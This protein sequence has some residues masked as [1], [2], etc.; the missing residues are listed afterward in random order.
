[1]SQS[2]AEAITE[3]EHRKHFVAL[4]GLRGL[5]AISVV[6]FHFMEMAILDYTKN[7]IGHGFLAVDFFF[8]LSGFVMGYAYDDRIRTLGFIRF[9]RHRLIRLHP[10]VVF[11]AVLG[12][13][14]FLFDPFM[15][16]PAS[17]GVGRI[18]ML[19]LTTLLVVPYPT[20]VE[21]THNLF[22]LNAPEWSLFWE[23]IASIVYALVLWRVARPALGVL[24]CIAALWLGICGYR[25]GWIYNGWDANGFW[26][27]AA[28]VS[29][30]FLAGLFIY[31][32]HL[33]WKNNLHFY[34]IGALLVLTFVMPF[35]SHE[36]LAEEL[37]VFVFYP[38][39]IMMGAG[40]HVSGVTEKLCS[41]LGR[42]SYPLY[43]THYV[44]LWIFMNFYQHHTIGY[45]MT[46]FIIGLSV[47][48]LTI[49]AYGVMRFVDEPLRRRLRHME[50]S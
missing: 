11:G 4:D 33:I 46:A 31:R 25:D 17:Y 30:S 40:I 7:F 13:L 50:K 49:F 37:V 38:S 21:R 23:Y 5:A 19:F 10:M 39:L 36:W 27:G 3:V 12:L 18:T 34:A 44:A 6:I 9:V 47:T 14:A 2:D 22:G 24:L 32:Y 28:R 29:F 15:P 45:G 20:M 8:C 35:F 1:M 16:V 26:T 41:F 48:S 43:M 42:L